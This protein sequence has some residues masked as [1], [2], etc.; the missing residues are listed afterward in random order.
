MNDPQFRTG[1]LLSNQINRSDTEEFRQDLFPADNHGTVNVAAFGTRVLDTSHDVGSRSRVDNV[2]GTNDV[3][4][5]ASF[6]AF[7]QLDNA[8][9][10][11]AS[12]SR[13]SNRHRSGTPQG[14]HQIL[15][16][17]GD[18]YQIRGW[19]VRNQVFVICNRLCKTSTGVRRIFWPAGLAILGSQIV[20]VA[21]V[22]FDVEDL[23]HILNSIKYMQVLI[24]LRVDGSMRITACRYARNLSRWVWFVRTINIANGIC[25]RCI[26][27]DD[28]WR[29]RVDRI[30]PI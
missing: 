20:R 3:D 26:F 30:W 21:F 6:T 4:K 23:R 1:L 14:N 15:S 19:V 12:L 8:H 17:G 24:V 16:I 22:C 5:L 18:G 10:G 25:V 7:R 2:R 29:W 28:R 27:K 13:M 9:S 11:T